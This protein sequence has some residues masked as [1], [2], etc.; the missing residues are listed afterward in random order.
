MA[1]E[2]KVGEGQ[3]LGQRPAVVPLAA[4]AQEQARPRRVVRWIHWRQPFNDNN[5][6]RPPD[7]FFSR[8]LAK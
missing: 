4:D 7:K 2:R 8:S 3:Q 1:G 6:V 5:K